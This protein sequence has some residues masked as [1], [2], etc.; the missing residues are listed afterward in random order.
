MERQQEF[1][2][3]QREMFE[4]ARTNSTTAETQE[5]FDYER[6][7][8]AYTTYDDQFQFEET[9]QQREE[10]KFEEFKFTDEEES[11]RFFAYIV[12]DNN[13]IN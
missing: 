2:R 9:K 13:G 1:E 5:E 12:G 6:D 11:Q 10:Q 7:E 8:E 4:R 3:M